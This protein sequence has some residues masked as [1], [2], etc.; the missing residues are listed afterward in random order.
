VKFEVE[1]GEDSYL[2]RLNNIYYD[3]DK[4]NIRKDAEP[5]LSKVLNFM[6][7]T[8]NVSVE[9]RSHT[10]SRGKATYNMWLSEKRAQSAQNYL[11][12]Q[13]AEKERLTAKGFGETL[14][15]NKCADG[16]KCTREE[17]QLNR[18]TEFKVVKINPTMSY[19]PKY[20]LESI[21]PAVRGTQ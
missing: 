7:A 3:F 2:V 12:K 16:V 13:G 18:R 19:V 4:F 6:K 1:K 5:E 17:H 14:L 15:L 11:L 10:D 21:F 8:P 20:K 9:L